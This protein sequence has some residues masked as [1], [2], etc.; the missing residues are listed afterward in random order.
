MTWNPRQLIGR[1][2]RGERVAAGI[3]AVGLLGLALV[4]PDIIGAP[5][6]NARTIAFTVGGTVVAA[7][8]LVLM[9]RFDVPPVVRL[10][11]LVVPFVGVSWW[12]LA[13]FFVDDVVDE[14]FATSIAAELEAEGAPA[15]DGAGP[16]SSTA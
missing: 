13:P 16:T 2:T 11:V 7:A 12:L 8:L 14:Q 9:L 3:A 1:I 6:E 4:E 5:F 10:F 15:T